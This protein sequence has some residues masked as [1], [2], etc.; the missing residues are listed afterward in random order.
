MLS[1]AQVD[2]STLALHLWPPEPMEGLPEPPEA[3]APLTAMR[4]SCTAVAG[5]VDAYSVLG[6]TAHGAPARKVGPQAAR[7]APRAE[8]ASGGS[9]LWVGGF[10][11]AFLGGWIPAG[12]DLGELVPWRKVKACTRFSVPRTFIDQ[13]FPSLR[14]GSPIAFQVK[15]AQ[16]EQPKVAAEQRVAGGCGSAQ[17][18]AAPPCSSSALAAVLA[19]K[20]VAEVEAIY[21]DRGVKGSCLQSVEGCLKMYTEW[22]CVYWEKVKRPCVCRSRPLKN[23]FV[24]AYR[25]CMESTGK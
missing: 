4:V 5:L 18:K 20:V 2:S 17:A 25:I 6:G 9:R 11:P 19:A 21:M 3:P 1:T 24:A 8:L 22:R 12:C 13:H 10:P 16:Q 7:Q 14:S 15:V 23:D